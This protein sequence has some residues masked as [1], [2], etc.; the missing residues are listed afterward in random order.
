LFANYR[1]G[2][3]Q[4]ADRYKRGTGNALMPATY[5]PQIVSITAVLGGWFKW[6]AAE[7]IVGAN[8]KK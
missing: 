6:Y 8:F 2:V 1:N 4:W 7:H 5:F 3:R